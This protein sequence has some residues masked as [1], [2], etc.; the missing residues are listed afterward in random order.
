M[1]KLLLPHL[2]FFFLCILRHKKVLSPKSEESR[3][4]QK[5]QSLFKIKMGFSELTLY[6]IHKVNGSMYQFDIMLSS[7]LTNRLRLEYGLGASEFRGNHTILN[8]YTDIKNQYL[9]MPVNIVYIRDFQNKISI[10]SGLGIYGNYLYSSKIYDSSEKSVGFA[11]GASFQYGVRFKITDDAEVSLS[12]EFQSDLTK[13][14][15]DYPL[16]YKQKIAGTSL[17]S[18][19]FVH[20]F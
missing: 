17:L 19:N 6:D 5:T 9:R 4:S 18:L 8:E 11:L 20:K 14:N 12:Y 2:L 7:R 13:M 10:I 16:P 1:K 15:S 3:D